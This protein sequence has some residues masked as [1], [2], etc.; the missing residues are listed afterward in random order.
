MTKEFLRRF[1]PK[2]QKSGD[3]CWTWTACRTSDGYG[4]IKGHRTRKL[5]YAHRVSYELVNGPIPDGLQIDHL[6]RN[7]SCVNPEHLE[8]VTP[9]RNTM[10]SRSLTAKLARQTHCKRGHPLSGD[11]LY[12]SALRRGQRQCLTCRRARERRYREAARL[13]P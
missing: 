1:W 11:N 9:R 4:Q 2:V 8:A 5:W 12:Q 6:C 10:R 13:A 3:G 7:P